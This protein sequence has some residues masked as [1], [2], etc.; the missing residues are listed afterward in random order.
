MQFKHKLDY[1]MSNED[2]FSFT[3]FVVWTSVILIL[4][5]ILFIFRDTIQDFF[6]SSI[7]KVGSIGP[8]Y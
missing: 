2:A 5:G 6:S 4:A 8:K 3:E 1:I 7:K